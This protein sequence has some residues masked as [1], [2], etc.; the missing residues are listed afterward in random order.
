MAATG[1]PG[2]VAVQEELDAI[3]PYSMHVSAP[4]QYSVAHTSAYK[5]SC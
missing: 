1:T 2:A 5:T 4:I 3:Q